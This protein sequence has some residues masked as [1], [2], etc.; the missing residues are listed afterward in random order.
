MRKRAANKVRG[1]L[2][3]TREPHGSWA[4]SIECAAPVRFS[5]SPEIARLMA[6]N[7]LYDAMGEDPDAAGIQHRKR[8]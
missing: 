4:V 5:G 1:N 3:R 6:G 2:G 7:S 8:Q